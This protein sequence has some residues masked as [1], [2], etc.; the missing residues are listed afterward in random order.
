MVCLPPCNLFF[1][2]FPYGFVLFLKR[3]HLFINCSFF[4]CSA[5]SPFWM[6][7]LLLPVMAPADTDEL[8]ATKGL[9]SFNTMQ[10][11]CWKQGSQGF[12]FQT[13]WPKGVWYDHLWPME[14]ELPWGMLHGHSHALIYFQNNLG[15][16]CLKVEL[17][18]DV[19]KRLDFRVAIW[20][21]ALTS[22]TSEK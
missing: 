14:D 18:Q 19:G 6:C 13:P 15:G 9:F 16:H 17:S 21:R 7:H 12:S 1:L 4:N 10:T 20:G 3:A 22:T 8:L 2:P 11:C 5:H